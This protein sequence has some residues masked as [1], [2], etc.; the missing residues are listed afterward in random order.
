MTNASGVVWKLNV[1]S[2]SSPIQAQVTSVQTKMTWEH[3][4]IK[5][6]QPNLQLNVIFK[7]IEEYLAFQAFVRLHQQDALQNDN[8]MVLNWPERNINAW[9][10][11]IKK[12]TG[13]YERFT[14]APTASFSVDLV[15]SIASAR[16]DLATIVDNNNAYWQSVIGYGSADGVLAPPTTREWEVAHGQ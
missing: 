14:Y 6:E 1:V 2:F 15:D 12:F 3:F 9:T 16:T 4:P 13:G 7:S 8:L 5:V 10:G 11:V